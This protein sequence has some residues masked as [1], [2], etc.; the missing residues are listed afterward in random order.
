MFLFVLISFF[1]NLVFIRCPAG[2]LSRGVGFRCW[3]TVLWACSV[4]LHNLK[5][6]DSSARNQMLASRKTPGFENGSPY[7]PFLV[8][9]SRPPAQECSDW[10]GPCV[11]QKN[12]QKEVKVQ[13]QGIEL[14]PDS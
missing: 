2:L 13:R 3:A 14:T 8:A 5:L 6:L 1:K 7:A 4:V 10:A 12:P 11:A 9:N